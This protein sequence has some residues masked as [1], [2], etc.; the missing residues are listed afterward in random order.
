[1]GNRH[2]TKRYI[3][4][5]AENHHEAILNISSESGFKKSQVQTLWKRFCVLDDDASGYI[6]RYELMNQIKGFKKN[7]LADPIV[8]LFVKETKFA[9]K[10][11]EIELKY[12]FCDV[13]QREEVVIPFLIFCRVLGNFNST[14]T[15]DAEE[16]KKKKLQLLFRLY[17]QDGDG[18]VSKDEIVSLLEKVA[19]S[20]GKDADI[21]KLNSIVQ[22][23]LFEVDEDSD[24][25]ISFEEFEQGLSR[26]N[27]NEKMTMRYN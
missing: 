22:R 19:K 8:D 26:I 24:G 1:M 17:D 25:N 23:A 4:D 5:T 21:E 9:A 2:S 15:K 13:S 7:P 18:S 14:N 27:L 10:R 3:G 16:A 12:E 6:S 20:K 11:N